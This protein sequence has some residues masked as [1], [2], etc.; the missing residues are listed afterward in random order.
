MPECTEI[1]AILS[2]YLDR[3]LP[4]DTC[5]TIDGHLQSCPRCQG[6]ATD[7]RRTIALCRK[8][9]AE[10]MPGPLAADNRQQLRT[11]FE[12]ALESIQKRPAV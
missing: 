4:P 9:R 6:V 10:D 8:F 7:L 1:A 2:D 11:A 12:K 5:S 3:N